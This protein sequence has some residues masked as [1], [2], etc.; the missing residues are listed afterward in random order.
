MASI[1]ENVKLDYCDVL[2]KPKRST[3]ASRKDVDLIK[4]YAFHNSQQLWH[5]IP[6]I[7]SNMTDYPD[8]LLTNIITTDD[9]YIWKGW[10]L[11][12]ISGGKRYR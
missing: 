10:L 4:K 8:C 9:T 2:I 1:E 6:L 7:A 12:L 3:L 11:V 5:G